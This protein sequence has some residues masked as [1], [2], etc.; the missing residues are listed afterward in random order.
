LAVDPHRAI[1][2]L[3]PLCTMR[4]ALNAKRARSRLKPREYALSACEP[5]FYHESRLEQDQGPNEGFAS[6]DDLD[7]QLMPLEQ[8]HS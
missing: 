3:P 8:T 1:L 2:G 7:I 4:I 5:S 6:L